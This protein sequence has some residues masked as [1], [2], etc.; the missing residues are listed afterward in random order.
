MDYLEEE[1]EGAVV[2]SCEERAADKRREKLRLA[3][4]REDRKRDFF[5][6][7]MLMLFGIMAGFGAAGTLTLAILFFIILPYYIF[8]AVRLYLHIKRLSNIGIM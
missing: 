4:E 1:E 8:R 2:K 5:A 7:I 3:K 6:V